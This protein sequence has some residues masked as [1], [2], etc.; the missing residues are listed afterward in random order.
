MHLVA[1]QSVR[2]PV[3]HARAL[4]QRPHDAFADS[5]VVVRQVQFRRARPRK[6]HPVRMGQ[7]HGAVAD[8]QFDGVGRL[9]GRCHR[10]IVFTLGGC[11]TERV[12]RGRATVDS[13]I[14]DL[15]SLLAGR[16]VAV[17]TGA[18]LSTDSGIPDYR[19]PNSPPRATR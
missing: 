10:S 19:S 2:E 3:Q 12:D 18:G 9:A 13:V 7:A 4:P 1:G 11:G 15:H 6:V 16:R 5:Q 14:D 8:D 17:L